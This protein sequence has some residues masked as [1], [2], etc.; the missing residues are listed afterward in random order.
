MSKIVEVI[1]KYKSLGIDK[2]LDWQ[3]FYLY[4]IITH[5]T[6]IEGSTVSEIENQLIFDKG[7]SCNKSVNEIMMNL[8]LKRAYERGLELLKTA[9]FTYSILT[10]KELSSIIMKNTGSVY[11]TINGEF[12][13]SKGDIRLLNVTSGR[14][15]E[16]YLAYDKIEKSLIEFCSWLNNERNHLN[17]KDIE[18]IYNLSFLAHYKLVLI[19]PFADGN[20]R[21]SRLIMNMLQQEYDVIHSIVKNEFKAEYINALAESRK[22]ENPLVFINFMKQNHIDNLNAEINEYIESQK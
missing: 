11:K 12:D 3:K 9:N 4:S 21:L 10:I 19:H 20:G 16:S 8:D 18:K 22:T 6:A 15:G 17:L 2:Q 7:L 14:G 13:S 5:S 1:E